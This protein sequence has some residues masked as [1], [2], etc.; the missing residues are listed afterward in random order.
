MRFLFFPF[1]FSFLPSFLPPIL[2][3]LLPSLLPSYTSLPP[4]V[5]LPSIFLPSVVHV[6]PIP[7]SSHTTF[8]TSF[9]HFSTA[10]RPPPFHLPSFRRTCTTY[11]SPLSPN[12]LT[13]FHPIYLT[14]CL[15]SHLLDCLPS[16]LLSPY[17]GFLFLIGF[18]LLDALEVA[19][20][21]AVVPFARSWRS[22]EREPDGAIALNQKEFRPP[23]F[24]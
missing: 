16:H 12:Y 10:F 7:S 21:E 5:L 18:S 17:I 3:S 6:L 1:H 24:F 22:P 9:L 15:P 20:G 14:D 8:T 19:A 11:D 23:R 4:S 2:P 13:T